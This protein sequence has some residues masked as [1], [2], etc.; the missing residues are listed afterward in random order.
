MPTAACATCAIDVG[1]SSFRVGTAPCHAGGWCL[2]WAGDAHKGH[3]A[4]LDPAV[5]V[6]V[7]RLLT[8]KSPKLGQPAYVSMHDCNS[9]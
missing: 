6:L 2:E 1:I 7:S 9:R 4:W 5:F 8:E 3:P